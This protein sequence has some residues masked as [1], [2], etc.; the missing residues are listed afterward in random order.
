MPEARAKARARGSRGK[1]PRRK[2][3]KRAS[4]PR[5]KSG[6]RWW[7]YAAAGAAAL[8][9]AFQ[10]YGPALHGPFVFDDIDLPYHLPN[11]PNGL[12]AWI[13]GVRPALMIS[14]W[15]N[16]RLSTETFFF[17]VCNVILHVA[18]SFLVFFI[19]RKLLQLADRA[20]AESAS[21]AS[22]PPSAA[23]GASRANLLPGFAA[24]VFLLHPVQTEAVSYVAGRSEDLSVLFFYAAFTVF[25]YRRLPAAS[26]KVALAVLAFFGAAVLTKEHTLVLPGLLLLTDYYWNPGFSWSG[27]RRNWRIYAPMALAGIL[28][29]ALVAKVLA[30]AGTAG[31]R[32][33]D[34]TWYQY[35]FTECRAFFVYLRLLVYPAGQ[36]LDHDYAISRNIL[37]HGAIFAMAAIL[38]LAAAAFYFRKRYPLASYGFFAYLLLMAPTSSFVPI[39]DPLAERRLYLPIIGMLLVAVAAL[40]RIRLDPRKL[41]GAMGCAA[42]LLAVLTYQRNELWA[43]DIAL[44]EDSVHKSPANARAHFQLAHTYYTYGRLPD[45]LT[46]YAEAARLKPPTYELLYDWGLTYSDAGQPEEAL[47]K[48][49]QA[50][51]REPTAQVYTQIATVYAKQKRWPEALEALA[52]AEKRDAA[53]DMIYDNR[54]GVR[55]NTNDL[56]GAVADYRRA[57]ALNPSNTHARQML[58]IVERQLHPTR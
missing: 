30:H 29:M 32:V 14:Y 46:Q 18:N 12:R 56:P 53:Y 58:D 52:E 20:A 7:I 4:A 28:G 55:A 5:P 42:A 22:A 41:A 37:D 44:W 1:S 57:L 50:A 36:N 8:Y 19:V 13:G 31:F 15:I 17:H 21:P 25:L 10:L 45:A 35:W 11:Y 51:A 43:S 23:T 6:T 9:L 38:V 39:Q 33:K 26:W 16:Y 49:R 24:A 27:I 47:A 2:E 34:F 48:L 40:Q 54:G 3:I